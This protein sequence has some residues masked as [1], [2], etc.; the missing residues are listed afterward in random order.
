V[1][2]APIRKSQQS[3]GTVSVQ[4]DRGVDVAS[5]LD[6]IVPAVRLGV[7]MSITEF[8]AFAAAI[9]ANG[10]DSA[11]NKIAPRGVHENSTVKLLA[12]ISE[13]LSRT[14]DESAK[15]VFSKS[16]IECLY[17]A[18]GPDAELDAHEFKAGL[19]G[20]I[21]E[22]GTANLVQSLFCLYV[23][24]SV[25]LRILDSVHLRGGGKALDRAYQNTEQ[26]CRNTVKQVLRAWS[27]DKNPPTMDPAMVRMFLSQVEARLACQRT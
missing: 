6:P 3:K 10:F 17:L 20:F 18:A 13:R 14:V 25:W 11:L 16:L 7:D 19:S 21:R 12:I 22:N 8:H 5:F 2:P 26:I 27:R 15:H 24:N 23:L 9:G 4:H 1:S